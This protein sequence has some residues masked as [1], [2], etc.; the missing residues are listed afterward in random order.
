MNFFLD[1]AGVLYYNTLMFQKLKLL[2]PWM[3]VATEIS[4]VFCCVLP[5]LVTVFAVIVNAGLLSA[6][7]VFLESIHDVIHDYEAPIILFSG[8]MM[9]IGWAV[10]IAATK[11]DCH[12]TG[13]VHSPCEIQKSKNLRILQL[14]TILF[15]VNIVIYFA[16]HKNMFDLT[17][18]SPHESIHLH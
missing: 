16:V 12:A 11:A 8:F 2:M 10:H 3:V 4:H 13:C 7:P 15:F 14:A 5:T 9:L 18:F 1:V 6:S 17:F